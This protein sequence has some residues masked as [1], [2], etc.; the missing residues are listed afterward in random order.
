MATACVI[1]SSGVIATVTAPVVDDADSAVIASQMTK[2]GM[3]NSNNDNS[4][5]ETSVAVDIDSKHLLQ[6]PGQ[7]V[8]Q[9]GDDES[10]ED[11]FEDE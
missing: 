2:T 7:E 6:V 11:N 3:N 4:K 10:N 8:L 5:P 1:S 9:L